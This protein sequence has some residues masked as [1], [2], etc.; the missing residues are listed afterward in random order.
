MKIT[1]EQLKPLSVS[2]LSE[3]EKKYDVSNVAIH[4]GELQKYLPMK[5]DMKILIYQ[6]DL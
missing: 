3:Y 1:G 2:Y 5:L 4:R 6:N